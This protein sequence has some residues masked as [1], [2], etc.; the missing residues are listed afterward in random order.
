VKNSMLVVI[1]FTSVSLDSHVTYPCILSVFH[2]RF[3]RRASKEQDI[4]CH[5]HAF[6]SV[7]LD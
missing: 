3:C 6:T 2:H 4:S 5:F 1:A 7:S